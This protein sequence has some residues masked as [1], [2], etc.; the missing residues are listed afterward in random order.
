MSSKKELVKQGNMLPAEVPDYGE[1]FG[2]GRAEQTGDTLVIPFLNVL[3][4]LSPQV[5]NANGKGIDG[6]KAGQF[7]N[8]VTGQLIAGPIDFVP[9]Y[10][11]HLYTEWKPRT[12]GGGFKG[13]REIVDPEVQAAIAGAKEFGKYKT[14]E[15]NDLVETFY[16]YGADCS[17]PA[18]PRPAVI[19]FTSTKIGP[20][21]KWNSGVY[22]FTIPTA[23]GKKVNPPI[24]AN[25]VTIRTVQQTNP[26][27]TFHTLEL[28]PKSGELKTSLLDP[29]DPRYLA[30]KAIRGMVTSGK[31]RAAEETQGGDAADT[32]T[33]F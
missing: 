9:A 11:E 17:D 18:D 33:P 22:M 16:L 26:K 6:A 31:A 15:G 30:A 2:V 8:T 23:D 25:L 29:T 4:S 27:G 19:A 3:Q 12:A 7:F 32:D 21:K 1:D 10:F 13:R 28:A 14:K 5:T 24:F 20:F